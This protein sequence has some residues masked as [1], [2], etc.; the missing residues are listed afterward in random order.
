MKKKC[1]CSDLK[2]HFGEQVR[3][4]WCATAIEQARCAKIAEDYPKRGLLSLME[5]GVGRLVSKL[6]ADEIRKKAKP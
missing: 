3:C 4:E 2:L 6:I 1:Y 5:I